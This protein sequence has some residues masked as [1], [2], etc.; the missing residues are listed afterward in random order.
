LNSFQFGDDF[1]RDLSVRLESP[2][3]QTAISE[4]AFSKAITYSAAQHRNTDNL[5]TRKRTLAVRL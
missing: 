2:L 4:Q 1:S 3:Q 5:T